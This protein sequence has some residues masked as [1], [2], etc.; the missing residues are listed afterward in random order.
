MSSTSN[1]EKVRVLLP[2]SL[3]VTIPVLLDAELDTGQVTGQDPDE[4]VDQVAL[5]E[6]ARAKSAA[7]PEVKRCIDTISAAAIRCKE[8]GEEITAR[9]CPFVGVLDETEI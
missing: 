7:M 1:V 5:A 3:V 2:I 8:H 4:T 6:E 9:V